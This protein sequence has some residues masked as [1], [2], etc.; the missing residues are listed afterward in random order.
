MTWTDLARTTRGLMQREATL[1]SCSLENEHRCSVSTI[2]IGAMIACLRPS[3]RWLIERA[4][5]IWC[6]REVGELETG[7][8]RY[9]S[10]KVHGKQRHSSVCGSTIE[11]RIVSRCPPVETSSTARDTIYDT[12]QLP[13][14]QII[15]WTIR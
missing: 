15:F 13:I 8:S 1:S 4:V 9:A 2:S 14:G 6:S 7:R 10:W 12:P 5:A 3:C 11:K